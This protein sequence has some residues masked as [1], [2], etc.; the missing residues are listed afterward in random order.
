METNGSNDILIHILTY[1]SEEKNLETLCIFHKIA[2]MAKVVDTRM[3]VMVGMAITPN[4]L[5]GLYVSVNKMQ[6]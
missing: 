2:V 4:C 5:T 1:M 3:L 6:S